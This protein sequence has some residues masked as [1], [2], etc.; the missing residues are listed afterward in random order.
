MQNIINLHLQLIRSILWR[1]I[2]E[3]SSVSLVDLCDDDSNIMSFFNK[4]I[5]CN[6]TSGYKWN[7]AI[8]LSITLGGFG[9]DRFYLGFIKV[10]Y[11]I[12]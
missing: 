12:K 6:W 10:K 8:I 5:E 7:N 9:I 4:K 2:Y 1:R 3:Y 11:F